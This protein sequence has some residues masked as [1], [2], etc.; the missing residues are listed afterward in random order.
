MLF[1]NPSA[2]LPY[3][4]AFVLPSSVVAAPAASSSACAN[5]AEKVPLGSVLSVSNAT[6]VPVETNLT[7]ITGAAGSNNYTLCRVQGQVVYGHNHSIGVELWLPA[8][9]HWNGR[10]MAVGKCS[11]LLGWVPSRLTSVGNGGFAGS[12]D[13]VNMLTQANSGFAVAGGDGGHLVANNGGSD[14][15]PGEAIPFFQNL[16]ETI[17]WIQ[18]SVGTLTPPTRDLAAAYYGK[19][20]SYSYYDG[21]STGGAQGHALAQFYPDLFDGIYAG[22]PGNWYSHLILSFLWNYVHS[23]NA[24]AISQDALNLIT[25][26]TIDKC[27]QIDGLKDGLIEDPLKCN[28]D[29]STLLCRYGQA[30]NGTDG[31][32]QCLTQAQVATYQAFKAGPKETDTGIQIYPGFSDGSESSWTFQETILA[33]FYAVPILQNL[34]FQD[35]NYDYF[36]FEFDSEDVRTVNITA[37]PY[38]DE[39]S[40]DLL[41]FKRNGGKLIVTQGWSDPFN[42]ATW[43]IQHLGA[44]DA[45]T[46]VKHAGQASDFYRLFMVPG[47]GHCGA[48]AAYP[49]I[50][51]NYHVVD[52]LMPWVEKGIAP[53]QMESSNPPVGGSGTRKLCAYPRTAK[54]V[55]GKVDN[56][57][58]YV[59]Q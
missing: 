6:T 38:I 15:H 31:K 54:Y 47:G 32:P 3:L 33:P 27:D 21:C 42:A 39:I 20:A 45:H 18:A 8:Q 16:E 43:P 7:A 14:T 52:V 34:V 36:G 46:R 29:I 28:F 59:C 50:P 2:V 57:K 22:S 11:L 17:E 56:W 51:A 9:Q 49:N 44:I 37:S 35:L 55:G 13:Y 23:Q 30:V 10:F 5:I 19:A 1:R 48:A 53:V 41:G 24:S 25:N 40:P 12:I 4:A 26:K 58:S